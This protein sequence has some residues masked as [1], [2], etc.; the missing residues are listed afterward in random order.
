MSVEGMISAFRLRITTLLNCCISFYAICFCISFFQHDA[1]GFEIV[2]KIFNSLGL[3]I[4]HEWLKWISNI[5]KN[6]KE[7][8]LEIIAN[9]VEGSPFLWLVISA[10]IFVAEHYEFSPI[11]VPT[12]SCMGFI[13]F[14]SVSS[15]IYSANFSWNCSWLI[16]LFIVACVLVVIIACQRYNKSE[17]S[18]SIIPIVGVVLGILYVIIYLPILVSGRDE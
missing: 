2:A 13:L 11:R 12:Q 6:L 17:W 9:L 1:T 16:F 8:D 15:D 4:M 18:E 14:A 5:P 10:A 7:H 3:E